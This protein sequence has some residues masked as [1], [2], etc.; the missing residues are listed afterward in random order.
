MTVLEMLTDNPKTRTERNYVVF[1]CTTSGCSGRAKV[2]VAD[3]GL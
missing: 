2:R 3:H 1:A